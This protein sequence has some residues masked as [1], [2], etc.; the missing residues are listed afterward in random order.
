MPAGSF[1]ILGSCSD[2][3]HNATDVGFMDASYEEHQLPILQQVDTLSYNL[4]RDV[5]K[6]YSVMVGSSLRKTDL[7]ALD[8][9]SPYA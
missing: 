7:L 4:C 9:S 2:D 1:R 8:V 6:V 5:L 3:D